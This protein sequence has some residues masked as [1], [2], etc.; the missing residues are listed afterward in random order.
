MRPY[1]SPF[2][3]SSALRLNLAQ[4]GESVGYFTLVGKDFDRSQRIVV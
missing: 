2:I 4:T 1:R 3:V